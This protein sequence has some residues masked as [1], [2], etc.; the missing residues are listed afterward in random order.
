MFQS[1]HSQLFLDEKLNEMNLNPQPHLLSELKNDMNII[2]NF[3]SSCESLGSEEFLAKEK[4]TS[5]N[6]LKKSKFS[7][8]FVTHCTKEDLKKDGASRTSYSRIYGTNYF[9]EN[10]LGKFKEE[11]AKNIERCPNGC[12]AFL[13]CD[14]DPFNIKVLQNFLKIYETGIDIAYY[15]AAAIEQVKQ[16]WENA[17]C[18]KNYLLIF[19][20]IEMPEKNGFETV[21]EIIHFWHDKGNLGCPIVATT[22]H[23]DE[24]ELEK[25]LSSG[26]KERIIKPINYQDL[27][28]L[29]GRLLRNQINDKE[30][31]N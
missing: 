30:R 1:S 3:N 20:D 4:E 29:I 5:A 21:Q 18:C 6:K 9:Q 13:V 12:P 8:K 17:F 26:L 14:D 31:I 10:S 2:L 16:R 23:D 27:N 25:I 24:K 15:G 28:Q 7:E 22:G 11:V 19:M